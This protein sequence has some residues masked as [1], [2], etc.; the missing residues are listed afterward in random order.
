M[1]EDT[2]SWDEAQTSL[3]KPEKCSEILCFG[4]AGKQHVRIMCW[5]LPSVGPGEVPEV[6]AAL[7]N[8]SEIW[9]PGWYH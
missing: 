1:K 3:E 2:L 4:P 5:E 7:W 8:S 9:L 6:G